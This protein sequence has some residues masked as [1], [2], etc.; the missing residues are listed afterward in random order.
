[1]MGMFYGFKP[2][3]FTA[4]K[5]HL[6]KKGL[7][8]KKRF[9]KGKDIKLLLQGVPSPGHQW[10]GDTRTLQSQGSASVC[11]EVPPGSQEEKS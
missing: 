6:N 10:P 4:C 8:K 11:P 7:Q 2:M 9:P 3:H 1:M 5:L